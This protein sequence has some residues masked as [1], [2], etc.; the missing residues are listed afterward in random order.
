MPALLMLD[1]PLLSHFSLGTS[2]RI[3]MRPTY[4]EKKL[5]VFLSTV[6]YLRFG[7]TTPYIDHDS[8]R[9]FN[10]DHFQP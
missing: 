9:S 2:T 4:F 8:A 7:G 5:V 6:C 10:L 3:Q 1:V